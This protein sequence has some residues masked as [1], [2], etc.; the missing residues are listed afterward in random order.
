M[1]AQQWTVLAGLKFSTEK[2]AQKAGERFRK[3]GRKMLR[4]LFFCKLT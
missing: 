3:G 1:G 2:R 4:L